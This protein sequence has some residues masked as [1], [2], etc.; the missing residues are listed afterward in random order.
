MKATLY[1]DRKNTEIKSQNNCNFPSPDSAAFQ[2]FPE[3]RKGKNVSFSL[4][5]DKKGKDK[6]EENKKGKEEEKMLLLSC[7]APCSCAVICDLAKKNIP[8][9]VLFYNP[10][11]AP[12]EEYQKRKEEN[13]RLCDTLKVEFIELPYETEQWFEK[14]KGLEKEP[15]R[16]RRCAACFELRLR[17]AARYAKE[18]GFGK[19][20]SVLGVSR[21]K[22]FNQ[23]TQ[24]GRQIGEEENIP[25][26]ET[27]WRKGGLENLRHALIKEYQM[28]E[29]TYCGCPFSKR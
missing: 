19:I 7:C 14:T 28:Y 26:L 3:E 15:E 1:Q 8:F 25:Y 2:N 6:K 17:R 11:I 4:V 16:G 18:N 5:S 13:K 20:S 29:Q 22:D 9:A 10:N 12:F 27:N 24:I 23:V 21:H